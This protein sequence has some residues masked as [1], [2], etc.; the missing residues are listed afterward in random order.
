MRIGPA[1]KFR[2]MW[3]MDPIMH[4]LASRGGGRLACAGAE[5]ASVWASQ[6]LHVQHVQL[7]VPAPSD[8]CSDSP[9]SA[10]INNA[11]IARRNSMPGGVAQAQACWRGVFEENLPHQTH[12]SRPPCRG[13]GFLATRQVPLVACPL[14]NASGS[15]SR[16]RALE[17]G[18]C[19]AHWLR[20]QGAPAPLREGRS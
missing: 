10:C 5:P 15:S 16:L 14:L 19:S 4:I 13:R 11:R 18:G 12:G 8:G 1:G 6:A 9:P 20:W 7:G 2:Q 17:Q 3:E